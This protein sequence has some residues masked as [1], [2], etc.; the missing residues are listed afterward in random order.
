[1]HEACVIARIAGGLGNQLFIYS[2]ARRLALH[3][4]APLVLDVNFFRSDWRY[5]R[6]YRLGS[7]PLANHN[8]RLSNTWVPAMIDQRMWRIK[9]CMEQMGLIPGRDGIVEHT[10]NVFEPYVLEARVLRETVLD[11]YWQDERYFKSIKEVLQRELVPKDC[12]DKHNQ[13][14]AEEIRNF[15]CI[16][17]HCRRQHHMLTGGRVRSARGRPGIDARYYARALEALVSAGETPRVF[18]F[19]DDPGWLHDQLPNSLSATVVDWNHGPGGEVNDLW[20][21]Q[22]CRRLVISNSTLSWWGGW[23][24]AD[25]RRIVT[26]RAQDLEYWI[27]GAAGWLEIDW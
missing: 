23:L 4:S 27:R 25:D 2:T 22:Q 15:D 8:V 12:P 9:R 19:G 26:P 16:G 11:G 7:Y 18:L 5:S 6:S 20:L 21:M 17:M 1:M 24:G 3:N 13:L 10:P 14:C